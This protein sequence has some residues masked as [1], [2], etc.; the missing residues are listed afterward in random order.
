MK[1]MIGCLTLVLLLG[2]SD[3]EGSGGSGGTAG[4]GGATGTTSATS[5]TTAM[6]GGGAGTGGSGPDSCVVQETWEVGVT[7]LVC[8][9]PEPCPPVIFYRDVEP[10]NP[11]PDPKPHFND[12]Q[13]AICLL[14]KLRDR[15]VAAVQYT[16]YPSGDSLGQ[17]K[18]EERI[19]ILDQEYGASN[20]ESWYDLTGYVYTTRRQILKPPSYFEGCLAKTDP[21]EMYDCMVAWSDG[22][23]EVDVPCPVK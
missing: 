15:E 5:T 18:K 1:S 9:L 14:T 17:Y 19:F 10:A 20:G 12:P 8:A 16:G 11:L 22:C 13:A 23:G 7:E 21:V 4:S 3:P 6:G 2:C